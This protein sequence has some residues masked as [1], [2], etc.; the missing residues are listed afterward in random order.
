MSAFASDS[1]KKPLLEIGSRLNLGDV[2]DEKERS[3]DSSIV[4][5]AELTGTHM[6]LHGFGLIAGEDFVNVRSVLVSE[7]R[8]VHWAGEGDRGASDRS[9]NTQG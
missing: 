6:G 5:R 3:S 9:H 7:R 4:R 2:P 8:T 1:P